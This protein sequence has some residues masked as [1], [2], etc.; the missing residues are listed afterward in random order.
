MGLGT[1]SCEDVENIVMQVEDG[2]KRD[3]ER[4]LE[5]RSNEESH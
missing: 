1:R 2:N 5:T 4:I 3:S